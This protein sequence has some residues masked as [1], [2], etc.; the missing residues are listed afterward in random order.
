MIFSKEKFKEHCKKNNF[1]MEF[2][3][4]DWLEKTDGKE[5][6]FIEGKDAGTCEGFVVLREWCEQVEE[7]TAREMFEALGFEFKEDDKVFEYRRLSKTEEKAVMFYKKEKAVDSYD[8]HEYDAMKMNGELLK[9]IVQ[10][11]KEL[12]WM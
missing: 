4:A 7:M 1:P 9:A 8:Y 11:M 6:I 2:Y 10:Q 12:G 5:A 3:G